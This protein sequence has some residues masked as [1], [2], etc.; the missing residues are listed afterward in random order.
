MRIFILLFVFP[1]Y[2]FAQNKSTT[3]FGSAKGILKKIYGNKNRTFYCDCPYQ[4]KSIKLKKC[5]LKL[6]KFK[7][8]SK[9]LEWEHIVPAHAFGQS[10]KE[11]REAKTICGFK[12]TKNGKKKKVSPRKCAKRNLEFALMEADLYNLVP[13]IGA[14]N[15]LRSNFSMAEL[16]SSEIEIC[17]G[18]MK[19]KRKFMPSDSK[20]GDV[21]RIY[22]YM[23]LAYPG[24]GVISNKNSKL[25]A[26]WDLLDPVDTQECKIAK[27]KEQYQGNKNPIMDA[28]CSKLKK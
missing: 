11:W 27:L 6:K 8:R 26:K 28:R 16:T 24:R 10:F 20:K 7:K 3:S 13:A 22:M 18:V 5:E 17:P 19:Q 15:A 23:D 14:V 9:R 1:T 4:K 25:F 21:A 2:L 12:K